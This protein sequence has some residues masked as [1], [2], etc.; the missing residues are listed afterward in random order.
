MARIGNN[1]GPGAV[2]LADNAINVLR[3]APARHLVHYYVGSAPFIVALTRFWADMSYDAFAPMN[4]TGDA[5]LVALAFIWMKCWHTIFMRGLFAWI[6]REPEPR[7]SPR[8]LLRMIVTQSFVHAFALPLIPLAVL[9]LAPLG[10]VVAF[11]HSVSLFGD[12]TEEDLREL[13]GRSWRLAA[14]WPIQS[15][16]LVWLLSPALLIT[17]VALFVGVTPIVD[18]LTP[19]WARA[20][21]TVYMSIVAIA[22]LP[23]SPLGLVVLF[24]IAGFLATLPALAAILLGTDV[25]LWSAAFSPGN[26]L[27]LVTITGLAFLVLDPVIKAAYVLRCFHGESLATGDDLRVELQGIVERD[28]ALAQ[29]DAP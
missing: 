12:G 7:W 11:L 24:N 1:A 13:G 16:R 19:P 22:L 28:A 17:A 6:R 18:A 4:C 9:A 23:L 26:T 15:V 10:F 21:G 29:G 5:L 27:F 2:T 20:L 8:R 25:L 14:L 3:A